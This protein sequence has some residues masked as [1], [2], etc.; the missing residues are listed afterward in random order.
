ML[1][2]K[3]S[4]GSC[5]LLIFLDR[6]QRLFV[7]GHRDNLALGSISGSG[8]DVGKHI[9]YL[10]LN[11]VGVNI[12]HNNK[13]LKVGT[14]PTTVVRTQIIVREVHDDVHGTNG[15]TVGIATANK[16]ILEGCLLHTHHGRTAHTPL[17]VD[18]ATLLVYLLILEQEVMA[19][20][21]QNQQARVNGTGSLHV[22]VINIVN[23][24]VKGCIGIQVLT[25]LHTNTLQILLQGITREVSSSVETH[26]LQEVRQ[27]ALILFLLNRTNFLSDV[28]VATFLG[29]L[30]MADVV[31]QTVRQDSRL[32][33]WIKGD[34]RHLL[35][36]NARHYCHQGKQNNVN[37]SFHNTF[38]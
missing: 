16:Q 4:V 34:V 20:I 12:A 13:T 10:L 21:V 17:F 38:F 23:G 6:S 5:L 8:S 18:N 19:P 1:E 29:P 11:L 32:N 14:I 28:E 33:S 26:M 24:L 2:H 15:H 9:L 36:R 3:K 27:S 25:E 22:Y 35:S 30:V 37:S 7:I 31:R